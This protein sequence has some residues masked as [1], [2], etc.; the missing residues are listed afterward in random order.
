MKYSQ[1][2]ITF[3]V[4]ILLASS[5]S[6]AKSDYLQLVE[7]K[8]DITS[9]YTWYKACNPTAIPFISQT[10]KDF[11]LTW[12]NYSGYLNKWN[13]E[14]RSNNSGFKA[15][16]KFVCSLYN[17]TLGNGTILYHNNCTLQQSQ[18]YV[19]E[20]YWN[21]SGQSLVGKILLPNTCLDFRI[22]GS[23]PIAYRNKSIN[24]D[25]IIGFAGY[26]FPEYAVWLA[27]WSNR[28]A[29][30]VNSTNGSRTNYPVGFFEGT[31]S[32]ARSMCLN[33]TGLIGKSA[34]DSDIRILDNATNATVPFEIIS[35]TSNSV[36]VV[37][38]A[39][40]TNNGNDSFYVYWNNNNT[41][42]ITFGTDFKDVSP[43]NITRGNVQFLTAD[44][45]F[46]Q[47]IEGSNKLG[48]PADANQLF[49]VLSQDNGAT[50]NLGRS[51]GSCQ[52]SQINGTVVKWLN[53]TN[54]H[55]G[56][57]CAFPAYNNFTRCSFSG[58][59]TTANDGVNY[60]FGDS[61]STPSSIF[62]RQDNGVFAK[63]HGSSAF[64]SSTAGFIAGGKDKYSTKFYVY[65]NAS[66]AG[67]YTMSNHSKWWTRESDINDPYVRWV[68]GTSDNT[69]HMQLMVMNLYHGVTS[70]NTSDQMHNDWSWLEMK[71]IITFSLAENI[72][73]NSQPL[74]VTG[75]SD[76]S[77]FTN[78]TDKG[79]N[80]TFTANISDANNDNVKLL[81][82]D[83]SGRSGTSC[84]NTEYC[85]VA[86]STPSFKSCQINTSDL[87]GVE[88]NWTSF[89]CDNNSACADGSSGSF[90]ITRPR[91]P[92]IYVNGSTVWN[93]TGLFD[94]PV[95]IES[96]DGELRND[97]SV[98][99]AVN[100]SCNIS[101]TFFSAGKGKLELALINIQ[102]DV[103]DTAPPTINNIS[104]EPDPIYINSSINISV[105]TTD[106]VNVT[107]V[108]ASHKETSIN[109]TYNE[110]TKLWR[111]TMATP[112][113]TGIFQLNIT[114]K[115][116]SNL[117]TTNS[118]SRSGTTEGTSCPTTCIAG[119]SGQSDILV[120]SEDIG[121]TPS[122]LLDNS[123]VTINVTIYN[124][125]GAQADNFRVELQVDNVHKSYNNI[126][127]KSRNS[128]ITNF[129][130]NATAGNHSIKIIADYTNLINESNESN[131][132][133]SIN[134][135]VQDLSPP[136]ISTVQTQRGSLNVKVN[137]TDNQNISSA[138]ATVNGTTIILSYNQTSKY[139][140][141]STNSVNPGAY[142]M[143]I[144]ATDIEGLTSSIQTSITVYPDPTDLVI[145]QEDLWFSN[146]SP[147]DQ[148]D[149]VINGRVINRGVNISANF[150]VEFL[151]NNVS[152]LNSTISVP[153]DTNLTILFN[154]TAVYG[155][156]TIT[157]K[158][159]SRNNVSEE[160]ESNN[161]VIR[162]IN[163][164]DT[165]SPTIN[166]LINPEI[167][168]EGSQFTIKANVTD[169]LNISKVNLTLNA[170][171]ILLLY[172]SSSKLYE[173]VTTLSPSP[174]TY[175]LTLMAMD[176]NS[177]SSTLKEN[178][179]VYG[180][181]PDLTNSV[182]D[183]ELLPDNVTENN[184]LY[185]N[186][187][188]SNKGGTDANSF[189]VELLV[190]KSSKAN[191][192][193]SI[194]KGSENITRF[195]WNASYGPH[196][197]TFKI[198]TENSVAESNE[199]NNLRN[200]T[201]FVLDITP[202]P[203]M[204]L[205][206]SPSNWTNQTTH[207]ISWA[208]VTDPNGMNR[209]EYRI[210]YGNWTNIWLNT[211]FLTPPSSEGIHTFYVRATDIPGNINEP[212]NVSIYI[213]LSPP[214]TPIIKEWHNGENW[215][216]HTTPYISWENPGDKGSGILN[217]TVQ[218]DAGQE[219]S[220]GS[221]LS[222]HSSA[223]A[224]G[225]YTFKVKA[226]DSLNQASNWSNI[227][228]VYI[229]TTEPAAPQINS[230]THPDNNTWY[231]INTPFFNL[232]PPA[233]H[234]GILGYYYIYDG[235]SSTS[236]DTMSFWTGNSTLNITGFGMAHFGING[237]NE[238][239][240]GL[241]N[242]EWYL[243]V[244][245]IDKAGNLGSNTSHFKIRI[246]ASKLVVSNTS[247]LNLTAR[248]GL[249]KFDI[250]SKYADNLSNIS[251]RFDTKENFVINSTINFTIEPS[252]IVF[253]FVEHNFSNS[254]VHNVNAT[255][256]N[257]NF[258]G[259]QNYSLNI[260]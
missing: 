232:T 127:V 80:V 157:V 135:S 260:P 84:L 228:T 189:K 27:S 40:L 48:R 136:S 38:I 65:W 256:S 108:S 115:D 152:K 52:F 199:T 154:W 82:C 7:N 208:A 122:T 22:V 93:Y 63:D 18:V 121:Y 74:F 59:D 161:E 216:N 42:P 132:E 95:T 205:V 131:N 246:N 94:G 86:F 14:V 173:N 129:I 244:K 57:L 190:D 37:F 78:T 214:N 210:N 180:S 39:N 222:Y 219:I 11:N 177:L 61:T 112:S 125:G 67:A 215:S 225:N 9:G 55:V 182:G 130:W 81:I 128:N 72:I 24:L 32:S 252:E 90:Y 150:T 145:R 96:F 68:G 41:A 28:T 114:A 79:T 235:N 89:A 97:L 75:T 170:S 176:S 194:K 258:A 20:Y 143:V 171:E 51:V 209:Y 159:D 141:G 224:S 134:V 196:N 181:Q 185:I 85:S 71:P 151:V 142:S 207:N 211:S 13:I 178:I 17:E 31:G 203:A 172:N 103:Y 179:V 229:D 139:Y 163:V 104:V 77:N 140:E 25:N 87:A 237:S 192:T 69:L 193:F 5:V 102:Y 119:G 26:S 6:A 4:I 2:L 212:N 144:R 49:D 204:N 233:E 227:I 257:I 12:L 109:L 70:G 165:T 217:F 230:T 201:V 195:T 53:C 124:F 23:Y 54:T 118:S 33:I 164:S 73:P 113:T 19:E 153:G 183:I 123:T 248:K 187:T 92:A 148:E 175:I 239:E 50:I 60:I 213:D 64:S 34:S 218:T 16:N 58:F 76:D 100:D 250:R 116:S 149:I 44:S 254:G 221:N 101:L 105:N 167:L 231:G 98:C 240:I 46:K 169:N 174:G 236:P 56:M 35:N 242:G 8:A 251:W 30:Y 155:N 188:V 259:W 245:A 197:L 247:L 166:Q 198:D 133:A 62:Y 91:N 147:S 99:Q 117:T 146:P 88:Y 110:T 243:H 156:N 29:I 223:L 220:I 21:N 120:N 206:A 47:V 3:S 106:N 186:M 137:I 253:V 126:S 255:A 36:C 191:N 43:L 162:S 138:I 83:I 1:A 241:E 45:G 168:Y 226:Y 10:A 200:R 184:L 202:P 158:V 15:S 160:N 111:G 234:S 107:L 66:W 249:F 238:S